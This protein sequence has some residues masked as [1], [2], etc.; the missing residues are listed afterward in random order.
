MTILIINETFDVD[1]KMKT[2]EMNFKH[3]LIK[4]PRFSEKR[5]LNLLG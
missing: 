3:F 1:M 2:K 5:G 4:H